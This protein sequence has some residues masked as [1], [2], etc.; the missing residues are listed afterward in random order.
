MVK[1]Y[2]IGSDEWNGLSKLI[3]ECGE[4]LQ[5]SGKIIGAEGAQR[6]WDGSNLVE[7]FENELAD[8]LAAIT[9]ILDHNSSL[10][11][12]RILLRSGAKLETFVKYDREARDNGRG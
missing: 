9:Y 5:T 10:D 3:E 7:R 6:H 8:L 1:P 2:C 12:K 11:V 4:V